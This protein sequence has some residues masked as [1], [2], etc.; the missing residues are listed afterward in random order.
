MDITLAAKGYDGEVPVWLWSYGNYRYELEIGF[1]YKGPKEFTI[2]DDTSYEE[3]LNRF[4]DVTEM[5]T[6]ILF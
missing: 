6:R 5:G 3:A 4:N 2:L 1:A